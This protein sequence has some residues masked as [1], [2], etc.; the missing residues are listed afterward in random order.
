MT[1]GCSVIRKGKSKNRGLSDEIL[2]ENNVAENIK[3][4]NITKNSFFVQKADIDISAPSGKEKVI[5]N[6]RY[7][8]PDKYLISIKSRTGIEA[9]RIFS[10]H[11]TILVNDRIN[12]KLYYGSNLD[13]KNRYGITNSVLPLIL[14]DFLIDSLSDFNK[15]KCLNGKLNSDYIVDG[16]VIK[17]IVDCNKY[18]TI[19][20]DTKN[21]V[22]GR[23]IE[24]S[25]H[26]FRKTRDVVFAGRIEFKD[27]HSMT[28][29]SI[30]IKKIEYPWAGNI[31]FIPGNK[32]EL[33]R[34]L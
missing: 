25:F 7:E 22:D 12:R 18:K 6:I 9:A 8:Y 27:L 31:K 1:T 20:I 11:D 3:N 4:R 5:A 32:Y 14:G 26:E 15:L 19:L 13:L 29:I 28:T 16:I 24:L 34:L 30:R 21:S 2:K 17:Y 10:S 23:M 33:M